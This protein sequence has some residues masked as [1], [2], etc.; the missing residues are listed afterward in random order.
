V[1]TIHDLAFFQMTESLEQLNPEWC[2]AIRRCSIDP[3]ADLA[4]YR[5]RCNF[6]LRLRQEVP[7]AL[8]RADRI[9]A[10]SEMTAR[11]LT[12]LM[13]VPRIKVRT[14]L[15]GITPGLSPVRNRE[16]IRDMLA[17]YNISGR[18]ILYVGVLDPNKDLH[19]LFAAFAKTSVSF[20]KNYQL[21]IAGPRNWFEPV[22]EDV[23]EQLGIRNQI[24]FTG[25]VP[26]GF[27]PIL[28]GGAAVVV[29]PS[30]L[31][32][33]GFTAL[34]A[35]ACGTPVIVVDAGSLPEVTG[36]AALRV[37]PRIPQALAEAIEKVSGDPGIAADLVSK[38]FIRS[39]EYSWERAAQQT[40][41]VYEEV[42]G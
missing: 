25:Y 31:E 5:E 21:V 12:E 6:F 38:G 7:V 23:A 11:D 4:A 37:P 24:H 32:G 16:A 29:C 18:Y 35:M 17:Q 3:A 20:R 40:L 1:V 33:F 41:E 39:K 22:L 13:G 34:E 2:T 9:I 42:A 28:Y 15:N 27:L 10:V 30:P 19:T 26:D 36:D 8:A 14:V